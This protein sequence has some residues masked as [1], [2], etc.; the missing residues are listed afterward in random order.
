MGHTVT[1]ITGMPKYNVPE[2]TAA[3]YKRRIFL[4]E[5]IHQI[6]VVRVPVFPFPRRIPFLRGLEHFLIAI[7]YFFA[8]LASKRHD[9]ILV[10]SPPLTLGLTAKWLQ[11]R[12]KSPFVFNVQDIYPQAMI[13]LGLLRNPLLIRI[14][15]AMERSIYRDAFAV[16]VHSSGNAKQLLSRVEAGKVRVISNW[17]DTERIKP[18]H[19]K[20]RLRSEYKLGQYFLVSFAG[21]MGFAQGLETVVDC[22]EILQSYPEILF[23]LVGDGPLKSELEIRVQ[24]KGLTNVQFL[25][26][27][28]REKYPDVLAA[29]DVCL[30]TLAKQVATPVVPAKLLSIM[31]SGRPVIASVP[32]DGDTAQIVRDSGAGICVE[33][34][35]ERQL[36]EAILKLYHTPELAQL[37]GRAGREYAIAHFSRQVCTR[38]YESLLLEAV[39]AHR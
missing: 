16:S 36:A 37:M 12:W 24:Q 34:G 25:P 4:R 33:A 3:K 29:S 17:V 7:E 14:S 5:T 22:A 18:V 38:Q 6:Q 8:G 10:Y 39:G 32:L 9:A 2:E 11:R 31:S 15:E 28:P 13:D 19:Q 35:N 21:I 30:V 27:Q 26:M 1:V 20:I 23:W